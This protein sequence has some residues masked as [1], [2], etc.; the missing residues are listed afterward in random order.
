M[1]TQ[2]VRRGAGF[3]R[4]ASLWQVVMSLNLLVGF[5]TYDDP[6]IGNG[7]TAGNLRTNA[8]VDHR[9]GGVSF[10][11]A[12]TDDLWDLSGETDTAAA[13]YRAYW[14]LLDNAGAASF[15]ASGVQSS[16]A[17]ALADLPALDGTKSVV[18]VYVAGPATD[19]DDAGGLAAQGT[20]YDGIPDGAPLRGLR[21][22]TYTAPK[23]L[24]ISGA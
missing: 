12:S 10:T 4:H 24:Q 18:G 1:A 11:K 16:V 20:I 15:A 14:L 5:G 19:F 21:G 8:S 13:Q 22:K 23:L 6:G 17:D 3:H 7:T 9:I 2:T